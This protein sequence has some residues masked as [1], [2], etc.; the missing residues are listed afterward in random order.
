MKTYKISYKNNIFQVIVRE[1]NGVGFLK[2]NKKNGKE[3]YKLPTA[4]E[5]LHLSTVVNKKAIQF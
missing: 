4:Q 3:E 2:I 1:D 5:F